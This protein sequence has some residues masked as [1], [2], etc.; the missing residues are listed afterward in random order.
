MIGMFVFFS[1]L[2]NNTTPRKV[3]NVPKSHSELL[4]S[5]AMM[6]AYLRGGMEAVDEQNRKAVKISN[7]KPEE[8]TIHEL[9][10]ENN[11]I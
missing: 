9:L 7:Q 3:H 1:D 11:N 10:S 6:S 5:R 4:T 2:N 8:I